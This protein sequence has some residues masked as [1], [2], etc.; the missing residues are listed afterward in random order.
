MIQRPQSIFLLIAIISLMLAMIVPIW[1]KQKEE[2]IYAESE[3]TYCLNAWSLQEIS[4]GKLVHT[5]QFPYACIGWFSLL[6][7]GMATYALFRYDDR[8]MQIKLGT[9][10]ALVMSMLLGYILYVTTKQDEYLPLEGPGK[11]QLGF[12]LLVVAS[13]SNVLAN[14]YLRKDEKRVR[15]ADRIR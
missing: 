1:H 7:V 13:A 3:K 4:Y 2:K 11:Y 9:L 5:T 14:R 6:A 8:V 12:L 15:A 10:N